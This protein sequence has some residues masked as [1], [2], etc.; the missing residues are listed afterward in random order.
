MESIRNDVI[1]EQASS[2][3]W[4]IEVCILCVVQKNL[5]KVFTVFCL[6]DRVQ[7]LLSFPEIF[8]GI[9]F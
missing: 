8:Y 9:P 1:L 7:Y 2:D 3:R 5:S 6:G 4:G